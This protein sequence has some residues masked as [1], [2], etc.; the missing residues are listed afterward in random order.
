MNTVDFS[1]DQII[2]PTY[3]INL[4]ERTERLEH[5]K[6]QFMGR[7]EFDVHIIAAC[8]H[9]IGAVGLWKSIVKVVELAIQH[10]DDVIIICEDDHQFT[11]HYKKESLLKNIIEAND[12][13]ISILSGGIAGFGQAVPLT[14]ER[15]WVSSFLSTQFI[16]VYKKMFTKILGYKFKK[17]E[18]ADIVLSQMTS[19][20]MVLFPFISTQRDFGYSDITAV[21]NEVEGLVSNMFERTHARFEKIHDAYLR[22]NQL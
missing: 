12:Q 8:K 10:H 13:D 6:A 9:K 18:V 5:I 17:V 21:H 2:I 15:M 4:K 7:P 11:K 19:H 3:V 20:K 1:Y 22:Y 16:V 14:S